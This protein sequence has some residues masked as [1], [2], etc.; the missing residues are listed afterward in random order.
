MEC[1]EP[2]VIK[3]WWSLVWGPYCSHPEC[4][5]QCTEIKSLGLFIFFIFIYF[6]QSRIYTVEVSEVR[7]P[8]CVHSIRWIKRTHKNWQLQ[9][10]SNLQNKRTRR[11]E[12]KFPV[13]DL[14][15]LYSNALPRF[16]S[17]RIRD[18]ATKRIMNF[19]NGR[20]S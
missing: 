3:R 1:L 15:I 6:R 9:K 13:P 2:Y 7:Q 10:I 8:R 18:G 12:I 14:N 4:P 19:R 17:A 16:S 20:R 5:I 11:T